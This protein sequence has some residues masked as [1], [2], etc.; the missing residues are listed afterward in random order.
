MARPV[1]YLR[2]VFQA[3]HGRR[4][5]VDFYINE[6][7]SSDNVEQMLGEVVAGKSLRVFMTL[8]S[9]TSTDPIFGSLATSQ[10]NSGIALTKHRAEVLV[11]DF[12]RRLHAETDRADTNLNLLGLAQ[13]FKGCSVHEYARHL[14][15][16]W[17]PTF[18]CYFAFTINDTAFD[19]ISEGSNLLNDQISTALASAFAQRAPG[20]HVAQFSS[21]SLTSASSTTNIPSTKFSQARAI[22]AAFR[23]LFLQEE[24]GNHGNV[25]QHRREAIP[26]FEEHSRR[27]KEAQ[28]GE[29]GRCE[30]PSRPQEGSAGRGTDVL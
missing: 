2:D 30:C 4:E 6:S 10:K 14:L 9:R 7:T 26:F 12:L 8:E 20:P 5:H 18:H 22:A 16:A 21:R 11:F 29:G 13:N 28:E 24:T 17:F 23:A 27:R 3:A 25:L 15:N 1:S 19:R